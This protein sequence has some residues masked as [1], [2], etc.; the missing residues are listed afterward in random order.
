MTGYRSE[1]RTEG[2]WVFVLVHATVIPST[3]L[4]R[5]SKLTTEVWSSRDLTLTAYTGSVTQVLV[6][7]GRC[8]NGRGRSRG[9]SQ[10]EGPRSRDY[11]RVGG[12]VPPETR[13]LVEG[14]R[15]E[16]GTDPKELPRG[17]VGWSTTS[18]SH[19]C[20]PGTRAQWSSSMVDGE[21][22]RVKYG[23]LTN[24]PETNGT[25]VILLRLE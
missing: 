2:P 13:D 23:S 5:G 6:K 17:E 15:G 8:K 3:S 19:L 18:P 9:T 1:S 12:D 7:E 24:G 25:C 20:R 4:T 10:R 14:R 11:V 21:R 16:S 22:R